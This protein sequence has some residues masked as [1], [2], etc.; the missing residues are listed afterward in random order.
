MQAK[1]RYRSSL[2]L[3]VKFQSAR[4]LCTIEKHNYLTD[5]VTR[6]LTIH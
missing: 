3:S 4:D 2:G 6:R 1:D 5:H